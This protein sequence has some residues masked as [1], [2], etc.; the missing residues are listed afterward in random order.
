MN[1]VFWPSLSENVDGPLAILR[2]PKIH[3]VVPVF[4]GTDGAILNRGVGRIIG[5][6]RRST[7]RTFS[8]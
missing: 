3:L 8:S 7:R 4:N 6:A 1:F 5:T 2:I